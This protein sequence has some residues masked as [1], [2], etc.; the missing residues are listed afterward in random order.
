M[1]GSARRQLCGATAGD[2]CVVPMSLLAP[3]KAMYVLLST[4]STCWVAPGPWLMATLSRDPGS[5]SLVIDI[6]N[7]PW[8]GPTGRDLFHLFFKGKKKI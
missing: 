1:W 8:L 7:A 2:G 5:W 4:F 3:L 6:L